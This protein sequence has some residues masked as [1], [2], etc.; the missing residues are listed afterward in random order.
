M[1]KVIITADIHFGVPSKLDDILWSVRTISE[2]AY[3]HDIDTIIVLGDMFNDR[4]SIGLDTLCAA[5][6]FFFDCKFRRGQNWITFPGNHDMFLRHSW[7]INSLKSIQDVVSVIGDIKILKLDDVRF[8]ILPFIHFENSYMAILRA[9]EKQVI[10]GDIL[11]THIGTMGA[12]K[13]VCFLLKDWSIVSFHDSPFDQVYTGHFHVHQKIGRNV[14]YPGSPIPFKFD[15]GDSEHGF[16]VYDLNSRSHEFVDIFDVGSKFFPDSRV[17]PNYFTI[18]EE[19]VDNINTNIINNNIIRV[20]TSRDYSQGERYD[21]E[22]SLRSRGACAV[23]WMN[24]AGS[25][26]FNDVRSKMAMAD[27]EDIFAAWLEVDKDNLSDLDINLLRKLNSE[28]VEVADN[29]YDCDDD[30]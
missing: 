4:V 1:S 22:K 12:V 28:V 27:R 21:I 25:L 6:D 9:V 14:W 16:L 20:V 13:N 29:L 10:D 26:E 24:L 2:Y 19:S 23:R 11:L 8:W 5:H 17:P 15:E 3:R 30:D 7:N 18:D